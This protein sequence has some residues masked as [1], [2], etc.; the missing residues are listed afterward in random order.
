MQWNGPLVCIFNNRSKLPQRWNYSVL[1]NDILTYLERQRDT[2][3]WKNFISEAEK[4]TWEDRWTETEKGRPLALDLRGGWGL[5]LS[6][7]FRIIFTAKTRHFQG[8]LRGWSR[9]HHVRRHP[10][11][12]GNLAIFYNAKKS[13]KL[14]FFC[15]YV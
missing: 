14:T 10:C 4:E 12:L 3:C 1:Y 2:A 13:P 7:F 11:K 5:I 8:C 6:S 9:G 15:T